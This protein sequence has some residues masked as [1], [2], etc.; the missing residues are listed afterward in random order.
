[1]VRPVIVRAGA[2][3]HCRRPGRASA[4]AG[5]AHHELAGMQPDPAPVRGTVA[6]GTRFLPLTLTAATLPGQV[7]QPT[8]T[9]AR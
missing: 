7:E 4:D 5:T 6:S 2:G 3:G 9:I 1:V 8:G